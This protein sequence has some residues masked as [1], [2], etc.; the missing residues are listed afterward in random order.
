MA[1]LERVLKLGLISVGLLFFPLALDAA[2]PAPGSREYQLKSVFLFNFAQFVD[3]P[4]SAFPPDTPFVIG[5]LGPDPFGTYLDELVRN[6]T[7]NGRSFTVQ[8]YTSPDQITA[9]HILFVASSEIDRLTDVLDRL[10]DR[11]TLT[12]ADMPGFAQHGGMIQFT[13]EKNRIG[14]KVNLAAV[15][16]RELKLS[17]KLLR[18]CEVVRSKK[19]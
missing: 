4:G 9:C 7:V 18:S 14:L 3:W 12:V 6:E 1:L 17:S 2:E 19:D 5:V 8:R 11:P 10:K 16:A 15:E 13:I